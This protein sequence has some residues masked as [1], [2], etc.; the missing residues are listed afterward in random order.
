MSGKRDKNSHIFG[1][2]ICEWYLL[3]LLKNFLFNFDK[4]KIF[5]FSKSFSL[6][7]V[8]FRLLDRFRIT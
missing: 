2:F 3:G 6:P 7:S 1:G 4:F 5:P 8:Q